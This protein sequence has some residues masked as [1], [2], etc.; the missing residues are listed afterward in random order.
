MDF[1][2]DK[3]LIK[4]SD[5]VANVLREVHLEIVVNIKEAQGYS[6]RFYTW[7]IIGTLWKLM[8]YPSQEN[9]RHAKYTVI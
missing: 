5:E 3:A 6:R 1:C 9:T 2:P 8:L 4:A 7:G